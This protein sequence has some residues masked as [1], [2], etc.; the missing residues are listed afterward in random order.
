M[1]FRSRPFILAGVALSVVGLSGIALVQR[2]AAQATQA[3]A[4]KAP[5][6]GEMFKNVN[7][8]TL[9]GLVVDDFLGAMG[10]ISADLGLDCADCHPG[11]GSDKVDWVFDT[12]RKKTARKMIE[13]VAVINKTNFN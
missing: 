13:M 1:T 7:T 10:A 2:A 4:A 3:A 8:S 12:P 11:A 6:A 9:K 5:V